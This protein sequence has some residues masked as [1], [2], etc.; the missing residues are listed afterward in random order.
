MYNSVVSHALTLLCN[1]HQHSLS[2][3]TGTLHPLD[4][5]FPLPSFNLGTHQSVFCLYEFDY[6]KDLI[7]VEFLPVEMG[8]FHGVTRKT[9][10]GSTCGRMRC[11]ST[12]YWTRHKRQSQVASVSSSSVHCGRSPALSSSSPEEEPGSRNSV[13]SVQSMPNLSPVQSLSPSR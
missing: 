7:S 13:S 9:F 3:Q 8:F 12:N 5:N 4:T 11:S 1:H 10:Q 6:C 2:S